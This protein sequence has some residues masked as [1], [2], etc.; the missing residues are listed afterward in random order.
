MTNNI[1][2]EPYAQA[3][4]CL[5]IAMREFENN[6]EFLMNE[7]DKFK[8]YYPEDTYSEFPYRLASVSLM[9]ADDGLDG[10]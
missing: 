6:D 4:I 2:I 1:S 7:F 10:G 5:L 9:H 8:K 3:M